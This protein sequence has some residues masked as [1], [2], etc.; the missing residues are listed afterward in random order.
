MLDLL[1]ITILAQIILETLPVSSSA[2][3]FIAKEFFQNYATGTKMLPSKELTELLNLP[4]LLVVG[5][6]FRK[7]I[8]SLLKLVIQALKSWKITTRAIIITRII[9]YAILINSITYAAYLLKNS[10]IQHSPSPHIVL[11]GLV[12]SMSFIFS[13]KWKQDLQ[14]SPLTL[15]KAILIGLAQ[16]LSLVPGISRFG[17][18]YVAARWLNLAPKRAFEFSFLLHAMLSVGLAVKTIALSGPFL[19]I[20]TPLLTTT[21][22]LIITPAT[23]I[24]Y[25]GLSLSWKLAV[26]RVFWHFG[27]YYLIPVVLLLLNFK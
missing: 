9:G 7:R 18:T 21:N 10:F 17:T 8:I 26:Q 5:F 25:A 13:L 23:L 24:S 27:A 14:N 6:F 15:S 11:L 12:A 19:S 1:E 4:T 16:S 20:I 22:L 3:V 2:H